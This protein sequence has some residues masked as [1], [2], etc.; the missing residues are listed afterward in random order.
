MMKKVFFAAAVLI[1]SCAALAAQ[2]PAAGRL[3]SGQTWADKEFTASYDGTTQRYIEI[4]PEGFDPEERVDLIVWLHGHG[5]D[6]HQVLADGG[7]CPAP[8]MAAQKR[9]AIVISPDYRAKKSW[10]GPAAEQDTLQLLALIKQRY[11]IG[12]TILV[13]GS[14]GGSSV[15]TFTALHPELVDA[16]VAYN[17]TANHLEY[18]TFHEAIALSFGGTKQEIPLEYKNRSAEYFPERFTMPLAVT[19]SGDDTIVPPESAMRLVGIVEKLQPNTWMN[20]DPEG[21]HATRLET[22]LEALD[23]VCGRLP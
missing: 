1:C 17:P 5:S 19:V 2:E 13:G 9:G 12:R 23:F 11:N 4:L 21:G 16:A 6:R 18:E 3:E 8:R 20:F 14:M 15:L 10:M 7:E 22:A